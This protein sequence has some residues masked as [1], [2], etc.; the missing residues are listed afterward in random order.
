MMNGSIDYSAL[1]FV[2]EYLGIRDIDLLITQL[3]T[4]RAHV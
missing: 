2:V 1:P 3:L 4:M